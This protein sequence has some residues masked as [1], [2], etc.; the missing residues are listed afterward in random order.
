[1]SHGPDIPAVQREVF[2]KPPLKTMLGQVRFPIVLRIADLGAL[3]GFQEAIQGDWPT[4]DQEQ[5]LSVTLG[6]QGLQQA[7]T[8]RAFR[9]TAADQT[10]SAVLTPEAITIEAGL[11]GEH[12][13]SYEEFTR[14]F[15]SVWTALIEHFK[16]AAVLQQ[17]L[18]YVNHI[19]RELPPAEWAT[20]INNELLGPITTSLGSGLLQAI[21]DL[22][23][24]R[25]D[26]T[27][28]FKHGLVQAGPES[29]QGYLLDFDYFGRE[30]R[31][32]P[33][34][35]TVMSRFDRYHETIY[36]FFRWCVTEQALQ[37]FRDAA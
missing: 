14:R 32:D 22:R 5:Q 13:T 2:A 7:G 30:Q 8:A 26:G 23:F 10:W 12:Y 24:Q 17:G 19:E 9:F 18:R 15:S 25:E 35:E 1:M 11:G 27:L 4:F 31:E 28:A 21:S 3:G 16:P 37:E 29:K 36:N 20:L 6:P 34:V 33:S